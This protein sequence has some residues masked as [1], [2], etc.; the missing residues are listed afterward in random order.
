MNIVSSQIKSGNCNPYYCPYCSGKNSIVFHT[1]KPPR[2]KSI[3]Y[4]PNGQ[5]KQINFED[6]PISHIEYPFDLYS[7]SLG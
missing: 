3:E 5:L 7:F 1:D 6:G 2:L 4:H